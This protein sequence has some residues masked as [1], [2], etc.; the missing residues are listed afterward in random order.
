MELRQ[1][2]DWIRLARELGLAGDGNT[3]PS[4]RDSATPSERL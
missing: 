3:N 1:L 2:P 4:S